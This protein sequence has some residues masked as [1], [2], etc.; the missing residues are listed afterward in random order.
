M[1]CLTFVER[2]YEAGYADWLKA[3]IFTV[4]AVVILYTVHKLLIKLIRYIDLCVFRKPAAVIKN[5]A[6]SLYSEYGRKYKNIKWSDIND[7]CYISNVETAICPCYKDD[8]KRKSHLVMM[9]YR[10]DYLVTE[11]LDI[12]ESQLFNILK[13]YMK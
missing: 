8:D 9:L 10:D 12:S 11:Y 6:L 5:D 3:V 2:T 7:F 1:S 4:S 13:K